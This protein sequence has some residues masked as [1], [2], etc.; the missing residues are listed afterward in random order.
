MCFTLRNLSPMLFI[1]FL[2]RW[3]FYGVPISFPTSLDTY[4]TES[5]NSSLSI[6][7]FKISLTLASHSNRTSYIS[8]SSF[9]IWGRF[10]TWNIKP[11]TLAS[12][13]LNSL[14]TSL[15]GLNWT[16]TRLTISNFSCR[17]KGPRLSFLLKQEYGISGYGGLSAF[18]PHLKTG[19]DRFL[20]F[21][22]SLSTFF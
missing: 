19:A 6:R 18:R 11:A 22:A 3:S 8:R 14:A 2:I 5:M 1:T 15:Y 20:I 9:R 4:C 10:L 21:L 7:E 17:D 16:Q 13:V 12:E